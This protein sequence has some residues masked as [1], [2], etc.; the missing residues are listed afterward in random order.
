MLAFQSDSR[1][2]ISHHTY[3]LLIEFESRTVRY[4]PNFFR[5][6]LWHKREVRGKNEAPSLTER[7]EKNKV[8]KI[9]IISLD[10]NRR[11]KR[12]QFKQNGYQ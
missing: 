4:R 12:F 6:D 3:L 11:E 2:L 8:R 5:S 1:A 10:S 9:F 7:T